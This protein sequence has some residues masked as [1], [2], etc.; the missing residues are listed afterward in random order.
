MTAVP[1]KFRINIFG[2]LRR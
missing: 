1:P 2:S